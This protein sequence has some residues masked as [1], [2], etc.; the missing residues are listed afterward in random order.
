MILPAF[1]FFGGIAVAYLFCFDTEDLEQ[2]LFDEAYPDGV[3]EKFEKSRHLHPEALVDFS[4]RAA[5]PHIMQRK[6]ALT[7]LALGIIMVLSSFGVFAQRMHAD[8]MTV[9]QRLEN[10]QDAVYA[11]AQTAFHGAR[12][13]GRHYCNLQP[14]SKVM[15]AN[16]AIQDIFG[17]FTSLTRLVYAQ[18]ER[19]STCYICQHHADQ[20]GHA[21]TNGILDTQSFNLVVTIEQ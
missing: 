14:D 13:I 3:P 16:E 6:F 10:K 20:G 18:G 8:P 17:Q 12:N 19:G 15:P 21:C 5:L 4:L 2:V 9:V 11:E 1:L 7:A